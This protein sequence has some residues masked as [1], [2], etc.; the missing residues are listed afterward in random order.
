MRLKYQ[1]T[2]EDNKT[3]TKEFDEPQD[4]LE[5]IRMNGHIITQMKKYHISTNR[6]NMMVRF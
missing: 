2:F 1:F 3:V 5:F 4:Y 6:R